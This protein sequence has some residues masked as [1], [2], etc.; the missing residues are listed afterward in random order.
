[1]S[2]INPISRAATM[3]GAWL[4]CSTPAFAQAGGDEARGDDRTPTLTVSA[5]AEVSVQPDRAVVRLGVMAQAP[6][7]AEAQ[8]QVNAAMQRVQEAVMGLDVPEQS[9]RTEELSL[10]PVYSD[11]RPMPGR[12]GEVQEPR[13]TGYRASNVVSVEVAELARIGEIIDA[14]IEAGANQ[15]QGV[16][17]SLRNNA[18][19]STQ[20]MRLAVEEARGQAEAVADAMGMRIVRVREVIA[21]GY[22]VRPPMP[23]AGARFAAADM[24]ETSVQPGQVDVTASVTVTYEIGDGTN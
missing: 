15:L 13:I 8:D 16:S 20:A 17:F 5:S 9:V 23:Y 24:A 3:G 7:A 10:Y 11:S 2:R 14:G 18:P 4:L 1:M 12:G 19:A 21:G 6:E 22:D